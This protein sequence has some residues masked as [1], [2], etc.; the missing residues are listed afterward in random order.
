MNVLKINILFHIGLLYL[1]IYCSNADEG[2][3]CY[4]KE[5][6]TFVHYPLGEDGWGSPNICGK[7]PTSIDVEWYG[8]DTLG[9]NYT[10]KKGTANVVGDDHIEIVQKARLS[11][12]NTEECDTFVNFEE[13]HGLNS[14]GLNELGRR[15]HWVLANTHLPDPFVFTFGVREMV[16][17]NTFLNVTKNSAVYMYTQG[18]E[19]FYFT[20]NEPEAFVLFKVI[21]DSWLEITENTRP[22]IRTTRINTTDKSCIYQF[23]TY[24][25]QEPDVDNSDFKMISICQRQEVHRY[26]Q[27][28]WSKGQFTDCTCKPEKSG[29]VKTSDNLKYPDC[30]YLSYLFDLSLNIDNTYIEFDTVNTTTWSDFLI[31]QRMDSLVFNLT[32]EGS[33]YITINNDFSLPTFGFTVYGGLKVNGVLTIETCAEYLF[34]KLEFK[35]IIIDS[36]IDDNSIVFAAEVSSECSNKLREKKILPACGNS[37]KRW[38]KTEKEVGY[39]N[40]DCDVKDETSFEQ[41]DCL[42]VSLMKDS[43]LDL[44]MK[45]SQFDGGE[46]DRYWENIMFSGNGNKTLKGKSHHI[47]KCTFSS[48]R[49]YIIDTNLYCE[50]AIIEK[51][52]NLDVQGNIDI[53]NLIIEGNYHNFNQQP[54]INLSNTSKLTGLKSINFQSITECIELIL[55]NNNYDQIDTKEIECTYGNDA[56]KCNIILTE[57]LFRICPSTNEKYEIECVVYGNNDKKWFEY[58]QCPCLEQNCTIL[59][60]T[61]ITQMKNEIKQTN[62]NGKI[63]IK[64]DITF[65][66]FDVF[67][68][69]IVNN[70]EGNNT[71][72]NNIQGNNIK[73]IIE[74]SV[75]IN[76]CTITKLSIKSS[77]SIKLNYED[78]SIDTIY[79]TELSNI[80]L[81]S[82]V[83][84]LSVNSIQTDEYL[85]NK[86][87]IELENSKDELEVT[88]GT[89]CN[90]SKVFMITKKRTI[91]GTI[92]LSCD[93]QIALIHGTSIINNNEEK[94]DE[95][96]ICERIG[97]N[98]HYCYNNNNNYIINEEILDTD[99]SCPCNMNNGVFCIIGILST[100]EVFKLDKNINELIIKESIT[101]EMEE[102]IIILTILEN[103]VNININ[104]NKNLIHVNT[105]TSTRISFSGTE[106]TVNILTNGLTLKPVDSNSLIVTNSE[107][108]YCTILYFNEAHS[109]GCLKCGDYI[110]NNGEC[111]KHN[112][113]TNCLKYINSGHCV[114]CKEGY[115][116]VIDEKNQMQC[117]KCGEGCLRC[118]S[119][120][121]I[122]CVEGKQIDGNKCTSVNED[123]CEIYKNEHCL[124]CP[125]GTFSQDLQHCKEECDNS[126]EL[127]YSD[128]L[129]CPICNTKEL[130]FMSNNE[131]QLS[132]SALSVS[133]KNE[134][135][136]KSGYHSS[137]NR[138][139]TC[140]DG[141]LEC[142]TE[143]CIK[144]DEN[145]LLSS[146][147]CLDNTGCNKIEDGRCLSCKEERNYYNIEEHKCI[148][149]D[150]DCEIIDLKGNCIEYRTNER[151]TNNMKE[152]F[153]QTNEVECV[154]KN[155]VCRVCPDGYY[156]N[157][158]TCDKCGEKCI[159]CKDNTKCRLCEKGYSVDEN[160]NCV[161]TTIPY[162]TNKIDNFCISCENGYYPNGITCEPCM[163]GC[164]TCISKDKCQRCSSEFL[165]NND[166]CITKEEAKKDKC[167]SIGTNEC[168]ECEES[169]YIQE[170]QCESCENIVTHCLKCNPM[171]G[172]CITCEHEYIIIDGKCIHYSEMSHCKDALDGNCN[173]CDNW[174]ALAYD[175]K[176]CV[177]YTSGWSVALIIIGI[178]LFIGLVILII[179]II[180]INYNKYEEKIKMKRMNGIFALR[181]CT[182]TMMNYPTIPT[183]LTNT[184]LI[185][186]QETME[187]NK[188]YTKGFYIGNKGKNLVE[189]SFK[190]NKD[191][192][193]RIEFSPEKLILQPNK[194]CYINLLFMPYCSFNIQI[195]FQIIIVEDNIK[196]GILDFKFSANTI[197]SYN[198]DPNLIQYDK[199]L[200]ENYNIIVTKG[201]YNTTPVIIRNIGMF[202]Y[203]GD[204]QK[205][206]EQPLTILET[207]NSNN[208]ISNYIGKVMLSNSNLIITEFAPMGT[209]QDIIDKKLQLPPLL[210]SRII[211]DAAKGIAVLHSKNYLHYNIKPANVLLITDDLNECSVAKITDFGYQSN[212]KKFNNHKIEVVDR[213]TYIAPEIMSGQ[214][215]TSKADIYSFALTMYAIDTL[216]NPYPINEFPYPWSISK[217]VCIGRRLPQHPEMGK[218]LYDIITNSWEQC[219]ADRFSIDEVVHD[220]KKLQN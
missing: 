193:F 15:S 20:K 46:N 40:C 180:I 166:K 111:P 24:Q 58:P 47:K 71:V 103:D 39:E 22:F 92:T 81:T 107:I 192:R 30:H 52:V 60:P 94:E 36:L 169:Y 121:C 62:F 164:I 165:L 157:R 147:K 66:N 218:A 175:R 14:I 23:S 19:F 97:F 17:S 9:G 213:P 118:T 67:N 127:C 63:I 216:T 139:K 25:L 201:Y 217:F 200:R 89:K 219:P 68:N 99:Y 215:F 85:L 10:I 48:G 59:V 205:E 189:I 93:N 178:T 203:T 142:D 73:V 64:G 28:F 69:L 212:Y 158:I 12:D 5:N 112:I 61:E 78:V 122:Q 153:I 31:P 49:S 43:K 53:K 13:G 6:N 155:G 208:Y 194:C 146:G 187:L 120:S 91:K 108:N 154:M 33:E 38:I 199:V 75:I 77:N 83:K 181:H 130:Y 37:I 84:K 183:I 168:R 148:E 27:C 106:N 35:D 74:E 184:T 65:I 123:N 54:I 3:V 136:C 220:L 45:R 152:S 21:N 124:K 140:S 131:C 4:W 161:N 2:I 80:I 87:L 204:E 138:C 162:C 191:Q 105:S 196:K 188:E 8:T 88:S 171:K 119:D 72:I 143:K 179:I 186:F 56:S 135:I 11:W 44:I 32:A 159:S 167:I 1:F 174:Y 163:N 185:E 96:R 113:I 190:I 128:N 50:E 170:G 132:D 16:W 141:C 207:L 110:P 145:Y 197:E 42:P 126:C 115:Y 177:R 209:L 210:R 144:C 150:S 214:K 79:D 76:S 70:T 198:T 137:S 117:N 86:P 90:Y 173:E 149:I 129:M 176:G 156:S 98:K 182:V 7:Y 26:V 18:Y 34:N 172:I 100:N 151:Y 101:I 109:F 55:T 104:G 133:H 29:S 114:E 51:S 41:F 211:L 102:S 195:P 160:G 116:L 206:Y 57:K 125:K 95:K 82:K 134:I 202:N